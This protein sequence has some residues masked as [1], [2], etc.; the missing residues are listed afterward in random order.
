MD[1]C[2]SCNKECLVRDMIYGIKLYVVVDENTRVIKY[3]FDDYN[4]AIRHIAITTDRM[5]THYLK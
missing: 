3:I 4:K 5:E 1:K 2:L